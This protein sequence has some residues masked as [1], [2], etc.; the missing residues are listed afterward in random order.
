MTDLYISPEALY[1]QW[2][3][4]QAPTVIDVR[5]VEEY[6]AGHIPGTLH[7]PGDELAQRLDEVPRDRPVVPY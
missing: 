5:G 2:T 1:R 6:A 3:T 4:E 7:I